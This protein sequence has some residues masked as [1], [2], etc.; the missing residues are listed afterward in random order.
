[1]FLYM[2]LYESFYN[3]HLFA[4]MRELF[5]TKAGN[6][7][8]ET[9]IMT[10]DIGLPLSVKEEIK[11]EVP[12]GN[13]N[14][15]DLLL[16]KDDVDKELVGRTSLMGLNDSDEF[17]D[18]PESTDYDHYD[19]DWHSDLTSEQMVLHKTFYVFTTCHMFVC[20]LLSKI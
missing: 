19:H 17:F 13:G 18:V 16:V 4:A 14:I 6:Y 1:M 9:I 2:I 8:S 12:Q 11:T 7:S 3:G 10:K 5:R 15:E 20:Y